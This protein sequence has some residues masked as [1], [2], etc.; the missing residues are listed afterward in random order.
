MLLSSYKKSLLLAEQIGARSILFPSISTGVFGYPREKAARVVWE[1]IS[2]Y[3]KNHV[4]P[5]EIGLVFFAPVDLAIFEKQIE[6][7]RLV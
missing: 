4:L 6:A 1:C 2:E 7:V 3:V 5:I